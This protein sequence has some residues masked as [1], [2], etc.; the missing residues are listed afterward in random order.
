MIN[1]ET[2]EIYCTECKKEIFDASQYDCRMMQWGIVAQ[3]QVEEAKEEESIVCTA[4]AGQ[5]QWDRGYFICWKCR[6]PAFL[7]EGKARPMWAEIQQPHIL[8]QLYA[9]IISSSTHNRRYVC[10]PWPTPS[11]KQVFEAVC[12]HHHYNMVREVP[13]IFYRR[14]GKGTVALG[15]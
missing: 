3:L 10:S 9:S 12:K 11:L 5:C 2:L 14:A 7:S 4:N 6:V 1:C 8:C 15:L 13:Y